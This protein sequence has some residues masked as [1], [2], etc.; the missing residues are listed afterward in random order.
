MSRAWTTCNHHQE[1][2]FWT[3]GL[4]I[5]R[6]QGNKG[7]AERYQKEEGGSG[8]WVKTPSDEAMCLFSK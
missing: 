6:P 2:L 1:A 7:I 3:V 5:H 4:C 8:K